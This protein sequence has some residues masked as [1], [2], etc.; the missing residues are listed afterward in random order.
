MKKMIA[1][2]AVALA[3]AAF[4]ECQ[5]IEPVKDTPA[6]PAWAY[7]WKFSGKTTKAVKSSCDDA[8]T[9][10]GTSLKIEGWSFYCDPE[11]G[12]FEAMEADEYFWQ[13]KPTKTLFKKGSGV[14]F[15]VA[16][17]IGK[18]G[19]EFEAYGVAQFADE[20]GNYD[21]LL[22]VAGLGKYDAK[23]AYV[24]SIKGN[25]AGLAA[26]PALVTGKDT[27]CTKAVSNV[28]LVWPCCGCPSEEA[29]SVAYGKW[30]IK[31]NKSWAKK[32]ANGQLSQKLYPSWAR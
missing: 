1:I 13:T 31:Y 14:A 7:K 12:D 24:K 3:G 25:F 2:A 19:K 28:S 15:E 22:A 23:K 8:I 4:A 9:R 20:A 17:V 16:N 29:G 11:C 30:S 27:A 21:Y 5:Y 6:E 18:K 10:T 26:A 32:A